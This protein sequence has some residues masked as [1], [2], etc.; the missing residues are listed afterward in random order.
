MSLPVKTFTTGPS[1][2]LDIGVLAYNGCTFSPLFATK[3]SGA[4][5]KDDAG[6]TTKLME[7]T[8]EA[9]GYVTASN[10]GTYIGATMS[11]MYKLLTQYGGALTYQG[12]AF[13]IVVNQSGSDV[14]SRDVAW[15][16]APELLEFQPLGGGLSAKVVW[17]VKVRMSMLTFNTIKSGDFVGAKPPRGGAGAGKAAISPLSVPLL[18]F[19]YES[20]ISYGE[21]GYSTISVKGILEVPL[22][23]IPSQGV[24]S[25]TYTADNFRSQIE[26]RVMSGIDLDKFRMVKRNFSLS[27]DKR[28][29]EWDFQAEEKPYMDL[30]PACTIARGS[31][32]VRPAKSGMGLVQWLCT[33]RA[34]YTVARGKPRRM[35]WGLFL[36]LLRLRMA[37]SLFAPDV[38]SVSG[39][40]KAGRVAGA[41][42]NSTRLTIAPIL[43][44]DVI[45]G[46]F[47]IKVDGKPA[48]ASRKAWLINFS[49]D[50]GLYLDSKT[51]TFSATWRL[52]SPFS[53]IIQA[54]GLWKKLPEQNSTGNNLWKTSMQAPVPGS[55]TGIQGAFSWAPNNVNPA[56]DIIVDFGS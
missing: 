10:D 24:R 52:V 51:I 9:D 50:E 37:H 1:A 36:A 53:H 42:F 48:S 40:S 33:L 31:Y 30:P 35:A 11:T 19:N 29:L 12:R 6:R 38:A 26:S 20:T 41:A 17:R 3:V 4:C 45:V 22:T 18:Q 32:S 7:F 16:P 47:G 54:S 13:D 55:G 44:T 25:M 5:V 27:R 49:F 43:S 2:L 14:N 46:L 8:I 39:D 21:D 15:G 28:T 34:T 23:R 56:T